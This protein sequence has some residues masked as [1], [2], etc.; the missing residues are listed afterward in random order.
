MTNDTTRKVMEADIPFGAIENGRA[1]MDRVEHHYDFTCEAGPLRSC[2]EWQEARLCFEQVAL[3]ATHAAVTPAPLAQST[4]EVEAIRARHEAV[5][6]RLADDAY[7]SSPN[8]SPVATRL[9][10]HAF[11]MAHADRAI[12]LRLLDAARADLAEVKDAAKPFPYLVSGWRVEP[13]DDEDLWIA[14]GEDGGAFPSGITFGMIR[15]LAAAL[16]DRPTPH[17]TEQKT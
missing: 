6:S 16:K 13:T 12:L 11:D 10:G 8:G 5:K 1:F 4:E 14:S 15:R 3:W 17:Q 7:Y 2:Y 9:Q